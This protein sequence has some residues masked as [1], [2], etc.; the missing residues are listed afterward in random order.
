MQKTSDLIWQDKQHQQLFVLID[1]INA[2]K[3]D[4]GVFRRLC[5]YAENHFQLEEEYMRELG[6]PKTEE[7]IDA[8]NRFRDE[9]TS[10]MN[11]FYDF[12][13]GF[14]E[15]LSVFL[16]E[17]LKKHIYGIDKDLED[18]VLRSNRK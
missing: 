10:M 4:A 16:S 14:R 1:D 11:N 15:A 2:K 7:H 9:L 18:F 17:W 6:Y 8:H 13:E 12:D 5:D 3:V